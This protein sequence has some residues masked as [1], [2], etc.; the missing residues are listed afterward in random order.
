MIDKQSTDKTLPGKMQISV[1]RFKNLIAHTKGED[2][3]GWLR[4]IFTIWWG[5]L[6]LIE[7]LKSIYIHS[8]IHSFTCV[9]DFSMPRADQ[10]FMLSKVYILIGR[11]DSHLIIIEQCDKW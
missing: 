7:V 4:E 10:N 1:F 5:I 8:L 3:L 9:L 2:V 11:V 6:I